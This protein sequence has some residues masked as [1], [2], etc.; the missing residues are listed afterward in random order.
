MCV[1]KTWTLHANLS[2]N[3]FHTCHARR[4]HWLLPFYTTFTDSDLGWESKGQHKQNLLA[5]FS[6]TLFNWSG[7]NFICCWSNSSWT[8]WY[9]FWDL[10]NKGNNCCLTGCFKILW[11]AFGLLGIDLVQSSHY[12]RYNQNLHCDIKLTYFD[13][14]SRSQECKKAKTSAP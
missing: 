10:I 7:W 6:C 2:T 1:A 12:D 9:Y 8:L 5:S 13:P 14:H 4:H 3:F 11:P